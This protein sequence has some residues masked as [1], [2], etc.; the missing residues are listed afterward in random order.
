M[1]KL[2]FDSGLHGVLANKYN[3]AT[4]I[5]TFTTPENAVAFLHN[6]QIKVSSRHL[7]YSD[8]GA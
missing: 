5:D 4:I 8:A 6:Y 2:T 7:S 1:T 3:F